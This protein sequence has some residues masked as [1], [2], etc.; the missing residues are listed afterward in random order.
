[1]FDIDEDFPFP[2]AQGNFI[3]GNYVAVFGD[4]EDE[5]FERLVFKLEPAT[6]AAELKFAAIET[7]V[8]ELIDDKGHCL[9]PA[10]WLKYSTGE[11]LEG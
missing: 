11:N 1:M 5:K 2:K 10:A 4:E 8:A 9:L 7:E 6:F 3:P